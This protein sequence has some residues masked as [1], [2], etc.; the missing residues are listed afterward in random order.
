MLLNCTVYVIITMPN[1]SKQWRK[2]ANNTK[3]AVYPFS[4]LPNM[5]IAKM[6]FHLGSCEEFPC[7]FKIC[8]ATIGVA[9]FVRWLRLAHFLFYRE[10]RKMAIRTVAVKCP[11]C[12]AA[13]DAGE[14][15]KTVFCA[16]CGEKV[17]LQNDNEY[18][19]RYVDEAKIKR[20]ET[21]KIKIETENMIRLKELEMEESHTRQ[22]DRL[23]HI[24]IKAWI[25]VS[26]IVIV[27]GIG[28][29]VFSG[30]NAFVNGTEYFM[31]I[32]FPVV[33]GGA[34]FIFKAIPEK[35]ENRVLMKNGGIM[36]PKGIF[37]YDE[38]N[39]KEVQGILRGAGFKN[40]K[41]V[42]LQ[43]VILGI[44]QKNGVIESIKINGKE[45]KSG[46]KVYRPDDVIVITY[47]G[48]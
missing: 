44:L 24:L 38:L 8:L 37:P 21:E 1:K 17:L 5:N 29:I 11:A 23:R 47:H 42:S 32:G 20:F 45:V 14:D 10:T 27:F 43:D 46:G 28:I 13:I 4:Q 6:Q 18:V 39:F 41:C 3:G 48:K 15:R 22:Y 19:H 16:Y 35:E 34:Y 31:F 25:A 26:V 2:L 30:S 36:L 40:V 9:F 7:L 12:G 33:I